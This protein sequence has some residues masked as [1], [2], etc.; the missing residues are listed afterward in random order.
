MVMLNQTKWRNL[1]CYRY[2]WL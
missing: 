1:V 2:I